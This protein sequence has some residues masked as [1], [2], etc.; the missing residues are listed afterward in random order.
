MHLIDR[1]TY[2]NLMRGVHPTYKIG[3]ALTVIALCLILN[4]LSVSLTAIGW[5]CLLVL[6]V[7]R[8]PIRM[9]VGLL[10]A[11]ALFLLASLIGIMLSITLDKPE[12]YQAGASGAGNQVLH[13]GW[14][15]GPF[16]VSTSSVAI[17]DSITIGMRS[18][19]AVSAL[20]FL[21][22]TTP[23]TDL[24]DQLR[25]WRI[26]ELLIDLVG[27]IYRFIFVLLETMERMLRAQRSRL[28][29][30]GRQ[31]A[32]QSAA[33]VGSQLFMDTYRRSAHL[34]IALD[35]RGYNG[36]LRVLSA[37]YAADHRWLGIFSGIIVS[38]LCA[39][40]FL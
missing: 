29:Y 26:P 38:L 39:A 33:M 16:W 10:T 32:M 30:A 3:L 5:M 7:A 28:G 21:A 6:G 22:L 9:F 25:R 1:Y 12:L 23:M 19:A 11:E 34:Q 24:L 13:W 31:Q 14:R 2:S 37:E 35:S 20:N 36:S 40:F 4:R 27:L 18:L 17:K 15:V 8:L